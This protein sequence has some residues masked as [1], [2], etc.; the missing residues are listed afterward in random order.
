[1]L[2][3]SLLLSSGWFNP[4]EV[5]AEQAHSGSLPLSTEEQ[6][7]VKRIERSYS[8]QAA[9]RVTAWRQLL[10]A[11][12]QQDELVQLK[13]IND[14]FNQLQFLDDIDVWGKEDYWATPLEFLGAGAG[15]CEEFSIAK[16]LSL[17]E[18]G[19][20]DEKLRLIYV[21]ALTLNQFHMVLA[22]Y[23]TPSAVPLLLDNLSPDILQAS[24]RP[25]LQPI[26]SFNGSKLW[27][28]KQR[29]QGQLVGDASRI[30][31]WQSLQQRVQHYQFAKPV[32]WLDSE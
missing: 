1:M 23:P 18:L 4:S 26:Y 27:L 25:D 14:F 22:Y 10:K 24:Q 21:K 28:M 29:G 3:I 15:D 16:Y 13:Q 7:I 8:K 12:S 30:K 32:L 31:H 11:S 5:A 6:E 2:L 9:M 19:V 20:E 17:R